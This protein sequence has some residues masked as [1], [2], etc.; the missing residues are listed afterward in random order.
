MV[1][2]Q[3]AEVKS[4]SAAF[5]LGQTYDPL[6]ERS[7]ARPDAPPDIV[8]AR[9][10]YEKARDFGSPDAAQ[11]LIQLRAATPVPAPRTTPK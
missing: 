11:R 3:A 9:T 2:E 10:W 7:A 6:I 4:A 1:L 5:A 8:M